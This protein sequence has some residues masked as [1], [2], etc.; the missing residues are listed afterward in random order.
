MYQTFDADP[1]VTGSI[2]LGTRLGRKKF[3]M[4]SLSV[5]WLD[6]TV[7]VVSNSRSGSG[8]D[9]ESIAELGM[10]CIESML[11]VRG[12]SSP[13]VRFGRTAGRFRIEVP[14]NVSWGFEGNPRIAGGVWGDPVPEVDNAL[15]YLQ[16]SAGVG[17]LPLHL[18]EHSERCIFVHEGTALFHFIPPDCNM[19]E[20]RSVVVEKGDVLAFSR[21]LIHTFS[22]PTDDAILCS[23]HSPYI[24][25][26]NPRQWSIPAWSGGQS[27]LLQCAIGGW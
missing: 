23:F 21:G 4:N 10:A 11:E 7:T 22:A 5:R 9:A 13:V 15:V 3:L 12:G 18:H 24:E 19:N 26:G 6:G 20:L 17:D 8:C 27:R 16:F 1:V 2:R 25:I 14:Q